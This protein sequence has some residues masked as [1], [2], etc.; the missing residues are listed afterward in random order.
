MAKFHA[1]E[2]ECDESAPHLL[3]IGQILQ[4]SGTRTHIFM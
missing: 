4:T 1:T 3:P 2:M